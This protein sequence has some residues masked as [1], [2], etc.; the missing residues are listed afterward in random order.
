M[1]YPKTLES[2]HKETSWDN[3]VVS[4]T[5]TQIEGAE[6]GLN[7]RMKL[8]PAVNYESQPTAA[9]ILE[10]AGGARRKQRVLKLLGASCTV[11]RGLGH[12][13]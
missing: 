3:R 9:M 4:K 12:L 11:A 1:K 7:A 8:F 13:S 6:V 2:Q 10:F 5:F